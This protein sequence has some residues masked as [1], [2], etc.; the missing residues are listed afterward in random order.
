MTADVYHAD[1]VRITPKSYSLEPVKLPP[2]AA[3][4]GRLFDGPPALVKAEAAAATYRMKV[5]K[6]VRVALR[7]G[8]HLAVDVYLPDAPGEK[9]PCLLAWGMWG[10][11]NQETVLWLKQYP[12]PYYDSPWWDGGLEGGDIEYFVSRGYVYVIPDPRGEGESEGDPPR[13]LVDL[14]RPDDIYD[15][16]EWAA[17]QPWSTG[18]V[19]MVGPSSYSFS[20]FIV[21][22]NAPPHLAALFPIGSFY[23]PADPFTGM[24]DAALYGIFHGGH[25]H[26]STHPVRQWGRPLSF[27]A[28]P[29]EELARRM[30]E[31]LEHPDIRYHAKFRSSLV[32]P[33]EP[34]MVDYLL[35]A[36]HPEPIPDGLDRVTVPFYVGVPAPGGG[37]GRI[38]WV[39]Y[40]AYN[41]LRSKAKKFLDFIP[42]EFARPV[43]EFQYETLRWHDHFLKGVDNGITD[44]PPVKLFVGGVNKW[45]FETEWPPAATRYTRLY[46]HPG[47]QLYPLPE[48]H[49]RPDTLHQPMLLKDPTVY[50]LAY[51]S[52]RYERATQIIGPAALHLEATIDQ[53]DVNWLAQVV[54]V[55][56][57]GTQQLM[58]EGWLRAGFRALDERASK[59]EAPVHLRQA[60]VPV[61]V[62]ERV[63]YAIN[64]MPTS[65]IVPAGHAVRLLLR[66]QDDLFGR[67]AVA[68]VYFLPRMVDVSADVHFGPD[69]Y[70]VLA[71]QPEAPAL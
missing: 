11:D 58:T 19:G 55:A 60:P 3:L 26:D 67:L 29:K 44:E 38:Y 22:P 45:K 5:E 33:R 50:A 13:S 47:K 37:G 7:D 25:I 28:L 66:T 71:T 18:K 53:D 68:G 16:I 4:T 57:D 41:K 69:S 64:L 27:D 2:G 51:T 35:S 56:P 17:R 34:V 10:K 8:V 70:L 6:N 36:F 52:P 59:P 46:L 31:M 30:K 54:D 43:V 1:Q 23:P 32:Y 65:W 63:R 24:I 39:G 9:F 40:E 15:V 48:S 21:A 12:Q 61:P 20:Q 62:G 49:A 42:G 14:H